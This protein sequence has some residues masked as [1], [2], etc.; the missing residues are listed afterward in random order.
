M[1]SAVDA[2]A[3]LLF[4]VPRPAAMFFVR[5]EALATMRDGG[6]FGIVLV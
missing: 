5:G 4:F 6:G 2:A 3:P 1:V